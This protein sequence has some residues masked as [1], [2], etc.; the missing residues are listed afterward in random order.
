M[1]SESIPHD[2]EENRFRNSLIDYNDFDVRKIIIIF[3]KR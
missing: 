3:V 1:L 2:V